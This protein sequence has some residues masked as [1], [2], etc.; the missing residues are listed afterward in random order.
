MK[1][2]LAL[3]STLAYLLDN[4]IGI[5]KFRFGLSAIIDLI[6][7]V[8][9]FIDAALS[10]YIVWIAIE[11]KVPSFVIFRMIINILINFLLGLIPIFGDLIYLIRK[12]NIKNLKLL[13]RYAPNIV[14]GE[15]V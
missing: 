6:P 9:D 3:A 5:G 12:V 7:V 14:E 15:I 8:G 2:H 13:K 11:M 10:F 4:S 1:S